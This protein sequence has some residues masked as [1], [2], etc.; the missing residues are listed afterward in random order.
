M[1]VNDY[2]VHFTTRTYDSHAA[3]VYLYISTIDTFLK[4][5]IYIKNSIN[6]FEFIESTPIQL[7]NVIKHYTSKYLR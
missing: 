5:Y 4:V 6:S 3:P 1:P 7:Y 2:I